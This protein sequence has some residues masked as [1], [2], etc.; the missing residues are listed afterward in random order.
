[1]PTLSLYHARTSI[2]RTRRGH[3]PQNAA[4]HGAAQNTTWAPSGVRHSHSEATGRAVAKGT[5]MAVMRR[6]LSTH[7]SMRSL[8]FQNQHR[9]IDQ[10]HLLHPADHRSNP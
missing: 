7:L 6:D 8:F 4:D 9:Q 2:L 10:Q 1:M 3:M 5:K